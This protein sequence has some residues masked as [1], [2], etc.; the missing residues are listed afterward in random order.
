[1]QCP[2]NCYICL[3]KT[4]IYF[5]N[6]KCDCKIYCHDECFNKLYI[7]NKCIICKNNISNKRFSFDITY[8]V[9]IY[10]YYNIINYLID[11]TLLNIYSK[12]D[13]FINLTFTLLISFFLFIFLSIY[14]YINNYFF[15][16]KYYPFLKFY[17]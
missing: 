2:D 5:K 13:L 17:I 12:L 14:I 7:F 10:F 8:R 16:K 3:E 1:M 9:I 6:E 4:N 11:F 15:S